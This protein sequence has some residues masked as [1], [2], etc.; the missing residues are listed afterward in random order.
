MN[1]KELLTSRLHDLSQRAYERSYSVYSDFLN[2]E[3]ISTLKALRDVGAYT[4]YGGYATAERCVA[5]FG[6]CEHFPIVC[7]EISPLQQKFAD[8]LTHRDFLGSLM[9]L[10]INRS[11]LGD[12][13]V[14]DNVGYLFCLNSISE[15]ICDNLTRIKHTTVNC[16]VLGELPE[17]LIKEPEEKDIIVASERADAVISAIY[18]LSRSDAKTLFLQEKVFANHKIISAS[19][20][21]QDGDIVSVR[22]YGKFRVYDNVRTTKKNRLVIKVGIYK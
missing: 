11:T 18:H 1:D 2:M 16:E 22:G 20:A 12:I 17:L 14:S 8:K 4:L 6:E 3:E 15:Y 19:Q 7:I 5:G 21:L 9:N 13:I 10:G